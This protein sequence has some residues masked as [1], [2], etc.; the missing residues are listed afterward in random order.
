MIKTVNTF[1]LRKFINDKFVNLNK[2]AYVFINRCESSYS[3]DEPP[4]PEHPIKRTFRILGNDM[5]TAKNKVESFVER[6]QGI[7]ELSNKILKS[8]YRDGIF[9]EHC[10]IVI[11]GGGAM[12]SSI[13]YWLKQRAPNAI[14]VTVIE[15]DPSYA[16]ASTCLSVGGLRQQF[17]LEENIKMSLFGAEFL[18]NINQ[19][20]SVEGHD[21]PDVQFTPCGYLF[22]ASEKG[23]Q[24]LEENAK[25]Q[26]KLGAKN[27]L[28]TPV[29][30]KQKFPWI[31]TDG[32]ALGCHGLENEGWFDPW[33]L[34]YAFKRKALSLGVEYID[35]EAIGFE[36]KKMPDL[37]M[38]G[39]EPGSYEGVDKVLVRT[40]SGEIRSVKFGIVIIAAGP[41]SAKVARMARIGTGDGMLSIPLPVEP[42]K[43]YVFCINCKN[44][45]GLNTP[46]T[47]DPS[48]TYFRREGLAGNYI[49]GRSPLPEEEPSVD[50]LDVDHD[51]FDKNIWPVLA[52]RVPAFEA[53]K[54]KNAWGGYYE[55]NTYD[56]N[57]IVGPHP[58]YI[59]M[60]IATGFSGHGIQHAPAVGRGVMEMIL[61]GGFETIDLTRMSF[62]RLIMDR[63]L[64]EENIV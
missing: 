60:Y 33:S 36:F 46:L 34:L 2:S 31:N 62:D 55:Y 12:G 8:P 61:D 5:K 38:D 4:K 22:L 35:G 39:M 9:P 29:K 54:V 20:L 24:Q 48:G 26:K 21:P 56:E 30:L 50:N 23:A 44:G 59:N 10:D 3:S 15:K 41:Y 43:R 14:T 64:I 53:V 47:I 40:E 17:S 11:I 27:E 18:R 63:P 51:F 25:L 32:I 19:H 28:L 6:M 49:C 58:Y 37:L 45:P 16:E 7:R 13:A 1:K 57:G 42:R 52:S